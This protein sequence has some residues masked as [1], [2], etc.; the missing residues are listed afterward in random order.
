MFK[1][2]CP[3]CNQSIEASD[4]DRGIQA[5]CPACGELFIVPEID[6]HT[7]EDLQTSEPIHQ[8][9]QETQF[10]APPPNQNNNQLKM[11]LGLAGA[12]LL[13][14]GVFCPMISI[15][16]AGTMNY[17]QHGSGGGIFILVF[18]AATVVISLM[19]K[20][21]LLWIPGIGSAGLIGYTF[22]SLQIRLSDAKQSLQDDLADN[23]FAGLAIMA[24][25]SVQIQWGFAVLAIGAILVLAAAATSQTKRVPQT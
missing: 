10:K 11:H 6:H 1:F 23:P 7:P 2:H 22:F 17:F 19:K 18:V 8:P 15:P 16:I 21:T 24:V 3:H 20:F 9:M 5:G 4:T 13:F 25:E 12:A 14:I